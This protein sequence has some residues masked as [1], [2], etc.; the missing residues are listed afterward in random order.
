MSQK[1]GEGEGLGIFGLQPSA[2]RKHEDNSHDFVES[3]DLQYK[4][5]ECISLLEQLLWNRFLP[6]HAGQMRQVNWGGGRI[7]NTTGSFA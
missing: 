7:R 1:P 3:P 4:M 2:H 5:R 6:N